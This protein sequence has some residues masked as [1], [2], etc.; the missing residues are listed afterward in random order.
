MN[1]SRLEIL[2]DFIAVD[3]FYKQMM[4]LQVN[5]CNVFELNRQLVLLKEF[6]KKTEE[7]NFAA[8]EHQDINQFLPTV[9]DAKEIHRLIIRRME[10]LDIIEFHTKIP[11]NFPYTIQEML[12]YIDYAEFCYK[13]VRSLI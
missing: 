12:E 3:K 13:N 5:Y 9:T 4:N 10:L 11:D 1:F 6:A 8:K 2:R 7:F